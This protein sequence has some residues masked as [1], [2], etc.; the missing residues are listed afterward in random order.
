MPIEIS[1]KIVEAFLEFLPVGSTILELGT[2]IG[3]QTLTKYFK[4]LSVENKPIWHTGHSEL[5]H[6]PRKELDIPSR[7]FS[8]LFP[9]ASFWYDPEVLKEKL[10]D[11]TYDA[12]LVDGP[13]TERERA[14]MWWYYGA[15]FDTSV[16]VIVDD[17]Q[18]HYDW[19]VAKQIAQV[20]RVDVIEVRDLTNKKYFAVIK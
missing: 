12:I 8:R 2:G 13:S 6:V 11:K 19:T 18:R 4:V 20:K 1:L 3:T 14:G 16:P 9:L 7:S 10:K 17:V 15:L 5:I